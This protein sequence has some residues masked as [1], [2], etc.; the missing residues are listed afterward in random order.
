MFGKALPPQPSLRPVTI[1]RLRDAITLWNYIVPSENTE[2]VIAAV[3]AI[4]ID[5][6]A[7]TWFDEEEQYRGIRNIMSYCL[8]LAYRNF[9]YLITFSEILVKC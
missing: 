9:G 2:N 1:D 3:E 8:Q 7:G 5:T 4:L 6:Q